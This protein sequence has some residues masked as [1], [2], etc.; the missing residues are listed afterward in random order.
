MFEGA[1]QQHNEVPLNPVRMALTKEKTY[2]D[3]G[4]KS[5][6]WHY[7]GGDVNEHSYYGVL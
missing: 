1:H 2:A 4:R 6:L 5:K 7:V 3:G